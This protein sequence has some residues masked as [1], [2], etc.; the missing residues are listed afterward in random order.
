[1]GLGPSGISVRKKR[2]GGEGEEEKRIGEKKEEGE[3]H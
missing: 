1:M 2:G 3:S